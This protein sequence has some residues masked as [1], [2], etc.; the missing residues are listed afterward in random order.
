MLQAA[1]V[2]AGTSAF[3]AVVPVVIDLAP[4]LAVAGEGVGVLLAFVKPDLTVELAGDLLVA[5][6][7]VIVVA[8]S[9]QYAAVEYEQYIAAVTVAAFDVIAPV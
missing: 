8:A 3:A 1:H 2:L 6:A 7:G 5:F 9:E 4:P